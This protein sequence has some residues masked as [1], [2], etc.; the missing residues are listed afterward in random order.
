MSGIGVKDLEQRNSPQKSMKVILERV[1]MAI[2]CW[3]VMAFPR[4]AEVKPWYGDL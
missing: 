4:L 1:P 2:C 3:L